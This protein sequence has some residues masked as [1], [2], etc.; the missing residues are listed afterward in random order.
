MTH[1]QDGVEARIGAQVAEE[2]S[3][4]SI[5]EEAEA[6]AEEAVTEEVVAEAEDEVEEEVTE[7]MEIRQ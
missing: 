4:H 1:V 6:E 5:K 2:E 7:V 3:R